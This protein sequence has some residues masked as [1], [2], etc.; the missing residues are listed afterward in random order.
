MQNSSALPSVRSGNA[1]RAIP[2][3]SCCHFSCSET[4]QQQQQ[5]EKETVEKISYERKKPQAS[6]HA[7]RQPLPYHLPVEEIEIHP[8]GDLTDMVCIGN[9]VTQELEY[10]PG[11]YFIRRFIRFKYAPKDKNGEGV[12]IGPL[13]ARAI[14]KG[15]ARPGLLAQILVD[16]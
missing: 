1:S 12:R 6:A 14:E 13:P 9:E 8:D 15:I 3:R 2:H 7:G 11:S 5:L 16:N 10:K 4:E